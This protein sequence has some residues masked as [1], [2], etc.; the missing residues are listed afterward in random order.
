MKDGEQKV[1]QAPDWLMK[2][3][4]EKMEAIK[5]YLDD[6]PAQIIMTPAREAP[7][8]TDESVE[9]WERCCDKCGTYCPPLEDNAEE[10]NFFTGYTQLRHGDKTVMFSFGI[11]PDCVE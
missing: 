9:N 10:A 2:L 6:Y 4:T 3:V 1:V 11:C 5:P 7:E 8:D